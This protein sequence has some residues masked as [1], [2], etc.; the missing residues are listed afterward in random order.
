MARKTDQKFISIDASGQ[1]LGRLAARISHLLR[2]KDCPDYSP[3]EAKPLRKVEVLN[4]EKV[5]LTGKKIDQKRYY[6]HSGRLGHLKEIR[7]KD[8][9]KTRPE[10]VL[11]QAVSGMLPKNR[12]RGRFLKQLIIVRVKRRDGGG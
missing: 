6:R 4:V 9:I 12:L 1:S 3:N 5:V 10:F 2:S 11:T 7:L 8:L